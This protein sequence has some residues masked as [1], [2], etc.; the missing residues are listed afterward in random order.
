MTSPEARPMASLP[1]REGRRGRGRSRLRARGDRPPTARRFPAGN[2][3]PIP[4][5]P[6]R[7]LEGEGDHCASRIGRGP[8]GP[9]P[10]RP[11]PVRLGEGAFGKDQEAFAAVQRLGY[12]GGVDRALLGVPALDA[13][14]AAALQEA[15]H[16]GIPAHLALGHEDEV[17]VEQSAQGDHVEVGRV[18]AHEQGGFSRFEAGEPSASPRPEGSGAAGRFARRRVRTGGPPAGR[19]TG[20]PPR[21]WER[22]WPGSRTTT[23]LARPGRGARTRWPRPPSGEGWQVSAG[24]GSS[25]PGPGRGLPR[26]R[27]P[28]CRCVGSCPTRS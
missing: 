16:E 23:L 25:R 15:S 6:P 9:Q 26:G 19:G 12:L 20:G 28:G 7:A 8:E 18:V 24:S 22:R 2:E 1:G 5:H 3:L 13:D 21:R 14:M 17:F 27:A 4:Q 11:N 10:K